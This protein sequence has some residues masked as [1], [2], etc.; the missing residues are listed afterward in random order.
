MKFSIIIPV[1]NVASYLRECLD[2]VLAQAFTDWEAI[3]IDDG[4]TD[5]SGAIL[6]EYAVRDARFRV[7]HQKNAGVSAARNAALDVAKGEWI[8]FVDADDWISE[9]WYSHFAELINLRPTADVIMCN[10][11][12]VDSRGERTRH[13]S[14]L[15]GI[16]TYTG[17]VLTRV[18][19]DK[20]LS[21]VALVW[22][23]V[24]RRSVIVQNGIRFVEGIPNGEDTFFAECFLTLA[25]GLVVDGNAA[26]Y[27]YRMRMDSAVRTYTLTRSRSAL[28][29]I[30]AKI[31]FIEKE[32]HG[33]AL[34]PFALKGAVAL[35]FVG[36]GLSLGDLWRYCWFLAS[37]DAYCRV[38][39]PFVGK[40]GN[41]K[42]RLLLSS[43]VYGPR[44]MRCM[45]LFVMNFA[46]K[47][48]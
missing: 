23:K 4:S 19:E 28:A 7:I 15:S 3:C 39:V 16:L 48:F 27:F 37:S 21:V 9:T 11:T 41:K 26:G 43:T 12:K 45:T 17:D 38:V 40:Y 36:L 1:Y 46:R 33:E 30:M 8:G 29:L 14:E 34:I 6:D 10:S 22:D 18:W 47:F 13:H 44:F 20:Q 25:K 32:P 35:P 24:F 5:G 42:R 31:D 2:S